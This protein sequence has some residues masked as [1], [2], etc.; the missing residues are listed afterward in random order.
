MS[1]LE[2]MPVEISSGQLDDMHNR[3]DESQAVRI[4]NKNLFYELK[5][6][7]K[8]KRNEWSRREMSRREMK[9][10]HINEDGVVV[11]IN[12]KGFLLKLLKHSSNDL[13][14]F[15]FFNFNQRR[16]DSFK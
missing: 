7:L 4:A 16:L 8:S 14:F 9:A 15:N 13:I 11:D 2:T 5:F 12:D 10:K 3:P 6:A 1:K